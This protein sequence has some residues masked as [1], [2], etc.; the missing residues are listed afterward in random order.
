MAA[1]LMWYSWRKARSSER[2]LLIPSVLNW[3]TVQ[4]LAG[5][6]ESLAE[7]VGEGEGWSG[8][9][10]ESGLGEGGGVGTGAAPAPARAGRPGSGCRLKLPGDEE[11]RLGEDSADDARRQPGQVQ[12]ALSRSGQPRSPA[13]VMWK[14]LWHEV[15]ARG[16]EP[17]W[18]AA[19]VLWHLK[20]LG[21]LVGFWGGGGWEVGPG[22]GGGGDRGVGARAAGESRGGEERAVD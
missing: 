21:L 4:L 16:G 13:Q 5:L 14:V 22:G 15:Q 17:P 12:A 1:I 7:L 19:I 20:H 8:G 6:V 3:R 2:E 18:R 9:G 11:A 10:G